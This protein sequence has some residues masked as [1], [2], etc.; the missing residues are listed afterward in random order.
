MTFRS[1][2][3]DPTHAGPIALVNPGQIDA[4]TYATIVRKT[5]VS[6][7]DVVFVPARARRLFARKEILLAKRNVQPM[8][9]EWIIGG[10]IPF[11][12]STLPE[13]ISMNVQRETDVCISP[14]RFISIA[15]HLYTFGEVSQG[16][17]TGRS[18]VATFY[19]VIEEDEER[20]ISESLLRSEYEEGF[21]LRP[22]GR[23]G[24]V[25]LINEHHGHPMLLDLFDDIFPSRLRALKE[26]GIALTRLF[27]AMFA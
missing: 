22:F 18:L 17:F 4:A 2:Q 13:A 14:N 11:N 16:K 3:K 26:V 9:S 19:C 21:G 27:H 25:Q 8:K 15:T 1:Y 5:V 23:K 6:C 7:V 24:L 12:A 10:R 20:R